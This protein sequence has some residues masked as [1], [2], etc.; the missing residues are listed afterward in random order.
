MTTTKPRFF[1]TAS[2]FAEWLAKNHATKKELIVGFYKK[3]SGKPSITYP[4]ALD[5]ALAM[6]WIDGVRRSVDADSYSVRFSPRTATSVWSAVNIKRVG[7][8]QQAGRMKPEGTAVF[9]GRDLKRSGIYS[10]ERERAAFGPAE[11]EVLGAVPKALAFFEQQS[12]YYKRVVA[13]WVMGAKKP[14][15]RAKRMERLIA[16]SRKGERIPPLASPSKA[17]TT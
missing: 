11:L 12:P 4:E 1:K 8:L 15:T 14:E 2:A 17:K 6:G 16:H 9:E 7:E 5:E 13:F 3:G 10:Y